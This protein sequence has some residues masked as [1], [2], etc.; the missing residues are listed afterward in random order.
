MKKTATFLFVVSFIASIVLT[1]FAY[2]MVVEWSIKQVASDPYMQPEMLNELKTRFHWKMFFACFFVLFFLISMPFVT[3]KAFRKFRLNREN[4]WKGLLALEVLG[5]ILGNFLTP[6][7]LGSTIAFVL[8]W[9]IPVVVN[10]L[11]F[12]LLGR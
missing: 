10:M 5:I 9:Q 11:A 6:P 7:D 4:W 12:R 8:V 2:H 3:S 1:Y